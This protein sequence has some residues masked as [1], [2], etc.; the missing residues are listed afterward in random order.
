MGR[1]PVVGLLVLALVAALVACSSNS[2]PP[3]A[4]GRAPRAAD[5]ELS[6]GPFLLPAEAD[7]A[8]PLDTAPPPAPPPTVPA[9]LSSTGVVVPVIGREGDGWKVST[10]CGRE[11][12]LTS[13]TPLASGPV[14]L[15]PGHGGY[16]PGAVGPNGLRES[17]LNLSV[18]RHAAAALERAGFA[19]VMTRNDDHGMNLVNRARLAVGLQAKAFVSVHH[20][21]ASWAPSAIPGSE[22]YHQEKSAESKRLAGLIYEEIVAALG[23]YDVPWVTSGAGVTWR[24]KANG[25]DWYAMV[26]QPR[27]VTAALAELAFISNPAEADLLAVPEVQRMEG[28]AVA[29]GIIRFLTTSD[30]GSGYVEG[31]QMPPR[32]RTGTGPRGG[33]GGW[34]ECD[35]PVL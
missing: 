24:T 23:A 19:T 16:D 30:A 9:V 4:S 14:V 5:T 1:R 28:E 29:R 6:A 2:P 17:E 18:S 20:N 32:P 10:P 7:V 15:D 26:N 21:A 25:D 3:T 13:A 34:D 12:V 31:G 11:A 22:M 8:A 33:G 27:G 35:D